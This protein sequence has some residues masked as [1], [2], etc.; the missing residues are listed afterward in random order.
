MVCFIM[1]YIMS[2]KGHLNKELEKR[3]D[4]TKEGKYIWKIK[5]MT[6]T[7]FFHHVA[8]IKELNKAVSPNGQLYT[9]HFNMLR[10]V[11]EKTAAF[12]GFTKFG[13]CIKKFEND[14]DEILYSR[15]I[16]ILS[17][18]NYSL[19]DAV[20]MNDENKKYFKQIYADFKAQFPFNENL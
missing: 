11:L 10:S 2:S 4:V 3:D 5:D 13:E 14:P 6:D 17:H 7:P 19:F 20:E 16:N 18:G 15:M 1:S 9:Y 8:I 12:H